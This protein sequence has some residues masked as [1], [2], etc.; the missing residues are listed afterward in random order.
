MSFSKSENTNIKRSE[1]SSTPADRPDA[2]AKYSN[3][4]LRMRKL[5]LKDDIEDIEDDSLTVESNKRRRNNKSCP[6]KDNVRKTCLSFEVHSSLLLEDELIEML[7]TESGKDFD[8]ESL[9]EDDLF[10]LAISEYR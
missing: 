8:M 2:F 3:D 9:V 6:V 5:L 7:A 10:D 4:V 1:M